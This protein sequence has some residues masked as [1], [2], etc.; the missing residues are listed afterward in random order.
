MWH[1]AISQEWHDR[2]E[3]M[4]SMFSFQSKDIK[5]WKDYT[6]R[7][8]REPKWSGLERVKGTIWSIIH[9]PWYEPYLI[10]LV[11]AS[12]MCS[13]GLFVSINFYSFELMVHSL[14]LSIILTKRKK[15]FKHVSEFWI[16]LRFAFQTF[17]LVLS[18]LN[19]QLMSCQYTSIYQL[20]KNF[21]SFR[22]MTNFKTCTSTKCY[23]SRLI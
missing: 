8:A 9:T 20:C 5:I 6:F 14:P 16:L 13:F 21:P 1:C 4:W 2:I 17:N 3:K 19:F 10:L 18:P 15:M 11:E 12:P 23:I 7:V 22:R